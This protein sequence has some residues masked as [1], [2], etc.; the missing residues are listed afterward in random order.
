MSG[1]CRPDSEKRIKPP[2]SVPARFLNYELAQKIITDFFSRVPT[3]RRTDLRYRSINFAHMKIVSFRRSINFA[4]MKILP[5]R[6]RTDENT[7]PRPHCRKRT[8]LARYRTRNSLAQLL[9]NRTTTPAINYSRN[10]LG[11]VA[12]T[13]IATPQDKR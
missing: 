13:N 7:L 4:H 6:R 3:S 11:A 2:Y 10:S 12:A 8:I 9:P 1:E 5:F